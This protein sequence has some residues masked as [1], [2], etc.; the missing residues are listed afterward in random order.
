[1]AVPF[2]DATTLLTSYTNAL[3]TAYHEQ[4]PEIHTRFGRVINRLFKPSKRRVDGNGVTIQCKTHNLHGARVKKD[5]NADFGYANRFGVDSFT[6]TCSETPSSN[7]LRRI[8]LPLQITHLDLKRR[9]TQKASAVDIVSEMVSDSMDDVME[10]TAIHRY[11]PDTG[12]IGTVSGTAKKN[13]A[14]TMASASTLTTTGGARFLV[15]SGSLAIFQ[16]GRQLDIYNGSTKRFTVEVTDYNPADGSVGVWG[17]NPTTRVASANAVSLSTITSGDSIYIEGSYGEGLKSM[18]Y[19]YTTPTASESFFG[20]D[21]TDAS[22]RWLDLHRS[23]PSTSTQFNPTH[24]DTLATELSYITEDEDDATLAV[25]SVELEQQFRKAVGNDVILQYP[26][27]E[28]KGRLIAQYGFDGML[29]RHPRIGRMVLN[30]DPLCPPDQIRGLRLGDWETYFPSGYETFEWLPGDT[31]GIWSRM[32][33]TN[34]GGGNTT[35]YRAE[36]M[37]ALCDVCL[38]PRRNWHL[39]NVTD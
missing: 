36:G 30:P 16:R 39:A 24:L 31:V 25:C 26:T 4:F 7:D 15:A 27:A 22:Y 8:S 13:D 23:G 3:R 18:G 33:S 5:L 32:A 20:R 28:Q 10:I 12:L 9:H 21:R 34:P 35:T 29:Y 11:L 14:K 37:M 1:M 17:V 38:A 2:D 6:I 19:W